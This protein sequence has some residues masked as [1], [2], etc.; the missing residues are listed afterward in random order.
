MVS[1]AADTSDSSLLLQFIILT[2]VRYN[3]AA[4]ATWAEIDGAEKLWTIPFARMKGRKMKRK[5]E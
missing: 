2:A 1:L 3:D 5:K 4:A